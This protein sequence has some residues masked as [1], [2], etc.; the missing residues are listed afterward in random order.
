M[1][2]ELVYVV[3]NALVVPAWLLLVLGPK[4]RTTQLVVHSG[5]Y[6][7]VFG[8]FYTICLI[9]SMF[10]GQ[11]AE[12]VGMATIAG[13]SALFSHPN[14]VLIG[15]S[16][17]LVFDLFVGAWIGRDAQRRGLPHMA[18]APCLI[19]SFL[20]G[21]VGLL[22]YILVR[23]VKGEGISLFEAPAEGAR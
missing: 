20:F 4:W 18:V 7:L 3:I 16:H 14:G 19:A 13:V 23:L 17:Y 6:P 22:A 11:S 9:A 2:L 12:G 1:S 5:I 21:P 15:W 8:A 10:F